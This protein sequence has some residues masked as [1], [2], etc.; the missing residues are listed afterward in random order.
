MTYP[1]PLPSFQG[2]PLPCPELSTHLDAEAYAWHEAEIEIWPIR[3][4]CF[5]NRAINLINDIHFRLIFQGEDF[6]A[7]SDFLFWYYFTQSLRGILLKD[8]YIPAL[9]YRVRQTGKHPYEVY[10]GWEFLSPHYEC[11]IEEAAE[12]LPPAAAPN[13]EPATVLRHCAEVLLRQAAGNSR[14]TQALEKQLADSWLLP[15]CRPTRQEPWLTAGDLTLGEQ[16]ATWRKQLSGAAGETGFQLGLQLQEASTEQPD[17]WRL[18][19]RVVSRRDPSLQRPLAD[20]WQLSGTARQHWEKD[21]GSD[22]EQRLLIDLGQA[23]RVY[24]ALWKGMETAE[25]SAIDLSLEEAFAFLNET[26]WILEDAGF[27]ISV[28]AW[29]TPQGRRRAKLRMRPAAT[30]KKAARSTT[31]SLLS[32]DQL[33]AYRYELTLG[34]EQIGEEEWTQLVETKTPLVQ[35]RGQWVVLDRERMKNMLEFWRRQGEAEENLDMRDWLKRTA[36]EADLF[37]VDPESALADML[38]KLRHQQHLQPIEDIPGLNAE[39]REYQKRGVAWLVFLEQLGLSGCLADDMGLGK[40]LQVIARLVMARDEAGRGPSLLIAPISVLG[41]W[42]KEIERF[43]PQ[44][45]TRLHHGSERC[46]N[47]RE[48]AAA[49]E[50]VDVV[51][52]SYPLALRDAKLFQAL[53]WRRIVLDE[54]QNI[55]NPEAKQT[56]AIFKLNADYRWALTGTPVENRLL[57]LWSIFNFLN[58]GYLGKQAA[59]RKAFEAPI[60]RDNDPMKSAMLKRLVEP[61]ILRRIKTDPAIIRDLPDKVENKQYCNLSKEQASLYEAVVRDVEQQLEAS[62][63]IQR[64]GLMLSTLMKLKQICNHPAQFLQDDSAFTAERSHKLERLGDMLADALA[65]GE[66]ALIFTQFTEIGARLE[67]YCRSHLDCQTYYLHGG[68]A[69]HTR[70]KMIGEFQNPETPPAVFILSLKAGGVGITLTRANHV[71]HFDRWWNPAVEDQATDRAFRIGQT[72]NVFVHKFITLGTLEERIDQMIDAKK[73]IA[74]AIVGN[75]ESWLTQL[76][77]ATFKQLIRLNQTAVLE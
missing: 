15:A 27:L 66:S 58:P 38:E 68:T 11:L 2:N 67:R 14:L 31:Q 5:N 61:F 43:A 56:K 49:A 8:Q 62:E 40:T 48:F 10:T 30:S 53:K 57:D 36:D 51:I 47:E 41:N 3:C 7:G 12:R 54:A 65:E 39:L 50:A 60:Q 16:W 26:A 35:F 42:R 33:L 73:K 59:F 52:V 22:F 71:F 25:P 72:K 74:G 45:K 63:G 29:W 44:L 55:K 28:P 9:R 20:Y 34:G 18:E 46:K 32:L 23:A 1:V 13:F 75:D 69:R 17:S 6:K 21:F 19:F 37:E 24:P 77:N 4:F 76:D 70:E 64:Q